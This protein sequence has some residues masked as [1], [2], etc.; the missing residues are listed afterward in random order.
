MRDRA[1]LPRLLVLT[2]V[3]GIVL[4]PLVTVALG[5][6]KNMG[7]LRVN[8]FGLPAEWY[9][10]NYRDAIMGSRLW[11]SLL[12]SVLLSFGTVFLTLVVGAMAAFAFAQI[13]FFGKR[14]LFSYFLLGLLFPAATAILPLFIRVRNLGLLDTP[15]GV[16]LP[17]AAFGLGMAILLLWG[18]FRQLPE[19]LWDAA[20]IDGCSHGRF[21]W[22]VV[23]PL[24]RP[25]LATVAVFTL[26]HSWNSYLLPLTLLNSP[27]TYPWTL[28]IM[29]YAGEYSTDWPGILA[30]ITLTLIPAVI[31]FLV[32]QKQIVAGLTSGA[33]KG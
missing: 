22:H 19:A 5:G 20:V 24:S 31:F 26:V 21:L 7:E 18:F 3:A 6:F 29:D 1:A 13:R 15:W 25:I 8:P 2:L 30:F 10:E 28:T 32:A 4:L 12:N 33:V 17:Q 14:M 11:R 27:G 9:W 23:L 16:I